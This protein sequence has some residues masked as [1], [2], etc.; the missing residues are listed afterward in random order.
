[1]R[2]DLPALDSRHLG[3][4]AADRPLFSEPRQPV[5]TRHDAPQQADL[6][7]YRACSRRLRPD[8]GRFAGRCADRRGARPQPKPMAAWLARLVNTPSLNLTVSAP[9]GALSAPHGSSAPG[10]ASPVGRLPRQGQPKAGGSSPTPLRSTPWH[11]DERDDDEEHLGLGPVLLPE[12]RRRL[13]DSARP[14]VGAVRRAQRPRSGPPRTLT[15]LGS[16]P[17]LHQASAPGRV[18]LPGPHRACHRKG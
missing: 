2:A 18:H 16:L 13:A 11:A 6:G 8:L 5:L 10:D 3:G 14:G 15:V 12:A 7:A 1:M 4:I 17:G 9:G